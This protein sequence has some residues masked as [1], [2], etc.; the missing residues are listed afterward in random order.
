[1]LMLS[2]KVK[3]IEDII[4]RLVDVLT[5]VQYL[6]FSEASTHQQ[7]LQWQLPSSLPRRMLKLTISLS[8]VAKLPISRSLVSSCRKHGCY[9]QSHIFR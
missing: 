8:C 9:M 1:M 2:G 7:C 6:I 3:N 4:R 5:A